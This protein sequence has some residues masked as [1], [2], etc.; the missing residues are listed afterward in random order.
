MELHAGFA[1]VLTLR[2]SMLQNIV[3]IYYEGKWS[4]AFSVFIPG[5]E[6]PIT[7]FAEVPQ[8]YLSRENSEEFIFD[9]RCRGKNEETGTFLT[10]DLRVN[11]PYD[12]TIGESRLI[13]TMRGADASINCQNLAFYPRDPILEN[14][15]PS[16]EKS[17][18]D[19]FFALVPKTLF[20]EPLSVY[21][22]TFFDFDP[23]LP[24]SNALAK[25]L[26]GFLVVGLDLPSTNGSVDNLVETT[27]GLDLGIFIN[28]S[29]VDDAFKRVKDSLKDSLTLQGFELNNLAIVSRNGYIE[30]NGNASAS[31]GAVAFS[32][33][34]EPKM[35]VR[36]GIVHCD[37][38]PV[39]YDDDSYIPRVSGRCWTSPSRDELWFEI[40]DKRFDLNVDLGWRVFEIVASVFTGGLAYLIIE[41]MIDSARFAV[42]GSISR[43]GPL[44][45]G[46]GERV[47]HISLP[48]IADP[49]ILVRVDHFDWHE[50]GLHAALTF[51][52][53]YQSKLARIIGIRSIPI[54]CLGILSL[55]YSIELPAGAYQDD[56]ALLVGWTLTSGSGERLFDYTGPAIDNLEFDIEFAK[57]TLFHEERFTISC[58]IS[59]AYGNAAERSWS[60][61]AEVKIEDRL[62]RSFPYVHWAHY[63]TVPI[64]RIESNGSRTFVGREEQFR[65][66]KIHRTRFPGRCWTASCFPGDLLR[67]PNAKNPTLIDGISRVE[68]FDDLPFEIADL[69]D[70]RNELCDYCFFGGPDK[71]SPLP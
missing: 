40:K 10:A 38:G 41:G 55:C 13:F 59:I 51:E 17:L 52:P 19:E 9:I 71:T 50:S 46:T 49:Q 24:A 45:I 58:C 28:A 44:I 8:L 26:D 16:L 53:Q 68:Y 42:S 43:F 6:I 12:V 69:L 54:E 39:V 57:P 18:L 30:L 60:T 34:I 20:H 2:Q 5:T 33:N 65:R 61:S 14:S 48:D 67:A 29:L 47:K 32:F 37:S 35:G 25:C 21:L 31:G 15:D 7:L 56:P 27:G 63:V 66:S 36:P 1:A 23:I 62:D 64:V 4:R 70:H 3:Q 11:V 22:G